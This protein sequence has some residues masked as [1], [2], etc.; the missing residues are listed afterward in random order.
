[1]RGGGGGGWKCQ[2]GTC[3]RGR[4]V[5]P[6][7]EL[8]ETMND[9]SIFQQTRDKRRKQVNSNNIF[10]LSNVPIPPCFGNESAKSKK[11]TNRQNKSAKS[12]KFSRRFGGV[13]GGGGGTSPPTT[14]QC[15]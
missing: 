1:M 12:A 2:N 5:L 9:A 14:T 15:P 3:P 11:P 7:H 8:Q 10:N 13:G 4:S 6:R